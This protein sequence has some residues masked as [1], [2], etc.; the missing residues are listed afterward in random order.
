MKSAALGC[1][2]PLVGLPCRGPGDLLE[3]ERFTILWD[4]TLLGGRGK[5]EAE[6]QYPVSLYKGCYEDT[7]EGDGEQGQT[8]VVDDDLPARTRQR[9][10]AEGKKVR[11]DGGG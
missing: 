11:R 1:L 7:A 3:I 10:G 8:A 2:D 5:E 6:L 9:P 4:V